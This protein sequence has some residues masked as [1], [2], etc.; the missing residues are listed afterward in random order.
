MKSN[1]NSNN[2]EIALNM[3]EQMNDLRVTD[4]KTI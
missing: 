2:Q 3:L 1:I 4:G